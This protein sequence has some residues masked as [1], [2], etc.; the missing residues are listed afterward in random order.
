MYQ[1]FSDLLYTTNKACYIN[2]HMA[3]FSKTKDKVVYS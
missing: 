3:A 2:A 1:I